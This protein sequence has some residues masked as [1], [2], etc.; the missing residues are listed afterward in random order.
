MLNSLEEI[1][2]LDFYKHTF[3]KQTNN[4]GSTKNINSKKFNGLKGLKWM[5]LTPS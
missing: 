4:T 1:E 2:S 3:Y 5:K